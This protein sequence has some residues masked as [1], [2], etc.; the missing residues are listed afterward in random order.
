MIQRD[1]H[2]LIDTL[3][4][5]QTTAYLQSNNYIHIHCIVVVFNSLCRYMSDQM[6][7]ESL[8]N[9]INYHWLNL[10]ITDCGMTGLSLHL[11]EQCAESEQLWLIQVTF[12]FWFDKTSTTVLALYCVCIVIHVSKLCLPKTKH[13]LTRLSNSPHIVSPDALTFLYIITR[14]FVLLYKRLSVRLGEEWI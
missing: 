11:F 2:L 12:V 9:F 14:R 7:A 6:W 8:S 5:P 10:K 1:S 3:I 13:R 4:I